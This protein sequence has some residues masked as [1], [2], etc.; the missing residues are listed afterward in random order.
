MINL[1]E[2][3]VCWKGP[4]LRLYIAGNSPSSRQAEHNLERLRLLIKPGRQRV[5]IIDVLA[6]P[7]LAE[8]AGILATPTLCY[9][10]LGRCRRIVGDLNDVRRILAFLGIETKANPA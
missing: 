8:K 3:N 5:E 7:E 1:A 2:E 10:H 9:E 6:N 4:T